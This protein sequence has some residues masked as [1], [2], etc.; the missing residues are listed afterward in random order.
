MNTL[1]PVG[2]SPTSAESPAEDKRGFECE[3]PAAREREGDPSPRCE[4]LRIRI[5][6]GAFSPE[7]DICLLLKH[8]RRRRDEWRRGEIHRRSPLTFGESENKFDAAVDGN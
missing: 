7:I 8:V 4:N 5:R 2:F 6:E 1:H 3:L